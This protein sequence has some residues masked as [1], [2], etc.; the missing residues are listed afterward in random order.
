MAPSA[1]D[2]DIL[3][4]RFTW[5]IIFDEPTRGVDVGAI[6]ETLSIRRRSVRSEIVCPQLV[7]SY[8]LRYPRAMAINI[9]DGRARSTRGGSGYPQAY[10]QR[11]GNSVAA[12]GDPLARTYRT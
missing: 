2:S 1:E 4:Q 12:H 10:W 7:S 8:G 11:C 5:Q 6:V 3:E 9:A